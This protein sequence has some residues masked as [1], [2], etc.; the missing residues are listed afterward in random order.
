MS[1]GLTTVHFKIFTFDQ[2]S[3]NDKPE[4]ISVVKMSVLEDTFSPR[5]VHREYLLFQGPAQ[6]PDLLRQIHGTA[7]VTINMPPALSHG[8]AVLVTVH[9]T[10]FVEDLPRAVLRAAVGCMED[11]PPTQQ[12]ELRKMLR[13]AQDLGSPY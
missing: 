11:F 13:H 7:P 2:V 9:Y 10:P 5:L 1:T 3:G 8:Q 6:L 4:P 12:D